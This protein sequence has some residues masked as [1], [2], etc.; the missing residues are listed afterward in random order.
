MMNTNLLALASGLSDPE[1]LAR[2]AALAGKERDA[3]VELVAH[4]AELDTRPSLTPP[5]ATV[6]SSL[7]APRSSS[8]RRTLPATGSTRRGPVGVFPSSWMPSPRAPCP[9]PRSECSARTSRRRTMRRCSPGP[10]AVAGARSKPWWRNWL[11]GR[12]SP[13]PSGNSQVLRQ[14]PCSSPRPRRRR[15]ASRR[16]RLG[17]PNRGRRSALHGRYRRRDVRS[18]RPPHRSAIAFSSRSARRATTSCD[19]FRLFSGARSRMVI[20]AQSSTVRS[21]SFLRGSKSRSWGRRRS[22]EHLER[23]FLEFHHIRPYALGGPT[24]AENISLRCR[25]HNQ[26]EA[27]LVFGPRTRNIEGDS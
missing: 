12:M 3:S 20:R 9:S 16:L 5:L 24:S 2:I 27:E 7:T 23:A 22:R 11:R 8:S 14:G 19:A 13:L 18:S 17:L 10:A 25:R 6:H 4:L 26:Y 21:P 15:H 1:L